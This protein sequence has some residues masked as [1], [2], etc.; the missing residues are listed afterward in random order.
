MHRTFGMVALTL[1]VGFAGCSA[2]DEDAASRDDA[3]VDSG[4]T[5]GTGG[6]G[7]TGGTTSDAGSDASSSDASAS[8][9]SNDEASTPIGSPGCGKLVTPGATDETIDVD[10]VERKYIL[11]VP[12]S[13]DPNTPLPLLFAWHGREGSAKQFRGNGTTYG[14][15]VEKAAAG[16]A[17]FVYPQGLPVTSE[18]TDTGWIDTDPDSR[19]FHLFDALLEKLEAELCIDDER[20]FS[21]GH[22]FGAYMS[23]ALGCHR[24]DVLRGIGAVAGGP[25]YK[26]STCPGTPLA[27]W[28][29]NS[30][31]DKIVDFDTRGIPARDYWIETNGCDANQTQPVEPS[32]CVAYQG[33]AKP[34]HWCAP[35]DKGH[36]FPTFAYAGIWNFFEAQ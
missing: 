35:T 34:L 4:S 16:K 27:A 1:V 11:S 31:D 13:Y 19:D 29:E 8:P 2:S 10:S 28:L 9:D 12:S 36:G 15:G 22:S 18:P 5:G 20:V 33:C 6:T 3:G 25:P 23:E 26:S 7:A 24:A 30:T 14:G 32:P 21:Y 17:I